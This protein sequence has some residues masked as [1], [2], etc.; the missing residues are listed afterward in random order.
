MLGS[1]P[2]GPRVKGG[3]EGARDEGGKGGS[4]W[5]ESG[6]VE[7]ASLGPFCFATFRFRA[8]AMPGCERV[9]ER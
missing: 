9:V 2:C 7:Y 8:Q 3:G 5:A 6:G 1:G 4:V